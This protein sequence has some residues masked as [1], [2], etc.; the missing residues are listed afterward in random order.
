[1][2]IRFA[3]DPAEVR[4]EHLESFFEGWPSR[5]APERSLA[6]IAGADAVVLA[7]DGERLVGFAT[8]L[9]DGAMFA[10]MPLVEVV[11]DRRGRG[12]GAELV[13]R[14]Q[15]R[16]AGLYGFDLCCDD[17]VVPFYERLGLGR[18]N[19]MITRNPAALA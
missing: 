5:P 14:L 15:E 3:E 10:S 16:F 18:V 17:D 7:W 12:I 4:P 1:M 19:G 6:A 9:T 2:T 8:A 13:R 11:A